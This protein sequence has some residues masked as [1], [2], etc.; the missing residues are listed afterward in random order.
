MRD[1]KETGELSR[2][3]GNSPWQS[4][5]WYLGKLLGNK[6]LPTCA[7]RVVDAD[8]VVVVNA[9]VGLINK[10]KNLPLPQ[11]ELALGQKVVCRN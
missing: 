3:L 9:N 8:R 7:H 5:S 11:I 10:S 2:N 1:S 4:S 6:F